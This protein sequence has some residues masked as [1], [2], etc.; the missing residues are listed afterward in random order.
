MGGIKIFYD[1]IDATQKSFNC[2]KHS[3]S[4]MKSSD[5]FIISDHLF[6]RV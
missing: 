6:Y 2:E 4:L 3:V 1:H 5:P